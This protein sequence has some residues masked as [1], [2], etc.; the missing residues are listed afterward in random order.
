VRAIR[1]VRTVVLMLLA[2]NF[3]DPIRVAIAQTT[4]QVPVPRPLDIPPTP[5]T[6]RAAPQ[7]CV[8]AVPEQWC[9]ERCNQAC[10]GER[11]TSAL[12]SSTTAMRAK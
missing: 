4:R 12:V 7:N 3:G 9:N 8:S 1:S 11:E 6:P 10:G 2:I 5:S